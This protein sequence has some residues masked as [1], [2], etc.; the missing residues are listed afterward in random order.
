VAINCAALPE[1]LIESELFG[2]VRGAFTDARVNH[3]GL[4]VQAKGGTLF[5]DE[6]G[7]LPLSLQPKLLRV[8]QERVIRPI[9]GAAEVPLDTRIITATNKDLEQAV[10]ASMFRQDLYYR[11][12]VV[13]LD[14]PPLRARGND[15]LLLAQHFVEVT[16][17]NQKRPQPAIDRVV[18]ERLLAYNWPGNVRELQNCIE[19]AITLSDGQTLCVQ[20]LPDRV[21]NHTNDAMDA[22][23]TAEFA[24]LDEVERRHILGVLAAVGGHKSMA[25]KILGLNRKTLYRKLRLYGVS[26]ESDTLD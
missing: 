16:C 20:D 10:A 22:A 21:R 4:F 1:A 13:Q 24:P 11:I 17:R 26:V 14:V 19:R 6:I 3:S 23:N 18:A 15:V 12:Q 25:A 7:E 2:H 8:L 9:G 5:L